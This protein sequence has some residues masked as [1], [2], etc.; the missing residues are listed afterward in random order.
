M[1]IKGSKSVA[2]AISILSFITLLFLG[3]IYLSGGWLFLA[4]FFVFLP[5]SNALAKWIT[6]VDVVKALFA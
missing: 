2:V 6:R 4:I 1:Q 3:A 5:L